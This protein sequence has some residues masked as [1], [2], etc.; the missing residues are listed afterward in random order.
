MW[1]SVMVQ[2]RVRGALGPGGS[3]QLAIVQVFRTD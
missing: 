3:M 1:V 2:V